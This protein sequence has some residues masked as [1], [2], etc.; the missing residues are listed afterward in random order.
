MTLAD[1]DTNLILTNNADRA[2]EG[3]ND[4]QL[5]QPGGKSFHVCQ[6]RQVVAKSGTNTS[7]RTCWLNFETMQVAPSGGHFCNRVS[8]G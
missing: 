2:I 8:I 3:N 1:E 7:D 4:M 6:W 5:T